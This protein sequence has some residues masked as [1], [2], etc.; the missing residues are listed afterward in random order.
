VLAAL[1]GTGKI[2]I[3]YYAG[4]NSVAA[5]EEAGIR[6]KTSPI[7]ALIDYARTRELR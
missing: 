2:G 1:V 6:I 4:V 7:S 3:A 5:A